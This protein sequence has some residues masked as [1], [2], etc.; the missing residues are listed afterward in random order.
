MSCALRAQRAYARRPAVEAL[1][2]HTGCNAI[3]RDSPHETADETSGGKDV[4]DSG[5]GCVKWSLPPVV[6]RA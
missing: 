4:D 6:S 2:K 1:G 3:N 5:L